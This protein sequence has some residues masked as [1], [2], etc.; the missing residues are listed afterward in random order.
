MTGGTDRF[1]DLLERVAQRPQV[2]VPVDA[3]E[4]LACLDH[5]GGAPAQRHL[6]V[7]PRL[8]L[9]AWVRQIEIMLST[10]FVERNVRASVGGMP[11]RSTVRVSDIPSRRLAAAPG[12]VR[13]SSAASAHSSAS[14]ASAESA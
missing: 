13:S 2:Q 1:G 7:A 11:R 3:A 14:A 10:A 8:T 4:L 6:P 9:P 12:W 5:P